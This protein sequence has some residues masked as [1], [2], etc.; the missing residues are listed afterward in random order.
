MSGEIE[1]RRAHE[2]AVFFVCEFP[3]GWM[4]HNTQYWMVIGG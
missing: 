1:Y 3:S 2:C 4:I